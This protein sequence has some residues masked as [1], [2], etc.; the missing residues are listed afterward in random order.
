LEATT[1]YEG[2]IFFGF[3]GDA[4][5]HG[6][7][8]QLAAS[9]MRQKIFGKETIRG[10]GFRFSLQ[11]SHYHYA[12]TRQWVFSGGTS[13]VIKRAVRA[14]FGYQYQRNQ[15]WISTGL[16]GTMLGGLEREDDNEQLLPNSESWK[17]FPEPYA[18]MG[19]RWPVTRRLA[20]QANFEA[21]PLF[22]YWRGMGNIGVAFDL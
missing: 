19:Y 4:G 15:F 2:L 14:Q 21:V 20:V 3:V 11:Y 16:A 13:W 18:A 9:W 22:I 1:G 6:N 7:T 12:E 8:V 5:A 10:H 17:I